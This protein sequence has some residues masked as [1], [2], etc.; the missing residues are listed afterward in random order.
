MLQYYNELLFCTIKGED[1][2]SICYL[3]LI[4][5]LIIIF[6]KNGIMAALRQYFF[7]FPFDS[8]RGF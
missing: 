3:G 5:I 2:S 6:E 7:L 8:R 4:T 1:I